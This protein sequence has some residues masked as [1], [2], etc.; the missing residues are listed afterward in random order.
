MHTV[1]I[2]PNKSKM[3]MFRNL[4]P[5]VQSVKA[6]HEIFVLL[7]LLGGIS[8]GMCVC[9]FL[10]SRAQKDLGKKSMSRSTGPDPISMNLCV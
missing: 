1:F 6:V 5:Y 4:H 8:F 7:N 10:S 9:V 2:A 3:L